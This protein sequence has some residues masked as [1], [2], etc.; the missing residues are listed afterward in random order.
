MPAMISIVPPSSSSRN[1]SRLPKKAAVALAKAF[2]ATFEGLVR[3]VLIIV[4]GF[5]GAFRALVPG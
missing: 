1:S 4:N 2:G 5:A 3:A